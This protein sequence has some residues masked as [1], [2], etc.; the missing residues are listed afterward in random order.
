VG[1]IFA[2][3]A[4]LAIQIAVEGSRNL[5]FAIS[6]LPSQLAADDAAI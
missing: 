2:E 4:W 5:I 3:F 6:S 1:N